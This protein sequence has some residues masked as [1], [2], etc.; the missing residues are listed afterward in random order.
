[1]D[2]W[3]IIQLLYL[4]GIAATFIY[5]LIMTLA[6]VIQDR[7]E[8]LNSVLLGYPLWYRMIVYFFAAL[9][10]F[11]VFPLFWPVA[12]FYIHYNKA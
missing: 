2:F 3:Q 5:F 8:E 7:W 4:A 11:V 10:V 12:L 6:V 1:M 9:I